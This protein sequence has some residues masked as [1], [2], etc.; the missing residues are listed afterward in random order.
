MEN[1]DEIDVVVEQTGGKS[2]H[3]WFDIFKQ[4]IYYLKIYIF[5]V[6]ISIISYL[7]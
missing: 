2:P 6:F 5:D 7:K 1:G 4:I 3:L